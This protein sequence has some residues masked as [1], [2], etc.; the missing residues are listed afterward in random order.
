M[1]QTIAIIG[2]AGTMGSGIAF[3]LAKAGHRILLAGKTLS[4]LEETKKKIL[5]S[6]PNADLDILDCSSEASWEADI[7]IP[8]VPYSEQAAVAEKIRNVVTGKIVISITNP[9]NAAYDGLATA[10]TTSAAEEL[11]ALLP[12]AKVVKAFNTV[13]GADFYT[14]VIDGKTADCFVAGE[15][16]EAVDTVS[17]LVLDAGF[18]PMAAGKLSVSRTLEAMMVLLIGLSMKNNYNWLAGWKV[19][20]NTES[21]A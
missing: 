6:V 21:R 18:H 1:K 3:S 5:A 20:H 9:L 15:N 19:L 11:A 4:K 12:H 2:A 7:V 13:F 8:A 10:P 14:P 16:A 17:G